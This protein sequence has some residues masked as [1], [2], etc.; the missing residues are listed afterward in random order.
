MK[1]YLLGAILAI[2]IA[3]PALSQTVAKKPSLMVVPSR[4]WCQ[5]NGFMQQYDNMGQTQ[6][7][8]DYQ[9]AFDNSKD[10]NLVVAKIGQL[11]AD[12]GF[13]LKLMSATLQSLQKEAA[14]DM[15]LTSK[16]TGAAVN[17]S[18]IDK[19]KKTAKADIWMEVYWSKTKV[20]FNT[21]VTF[22]LSGVDAYTD[23]QIANCQGT[24]QPSS[25]PEI[26]VLL[27]EAVIN[28]LNQF[29]EQLQVAF[30]DWFANG[31]I[32]KFRIKTWEDSEYDL[33]SEFDGEELG[34]I[35]EDWI[36]E[37]TVK[38]QFTTDDATENMMVFSNV[39]IPMISESGRALDARSWSRG[40]SKMLRDKYE[41]SSKVMT[42]GLGQAT[43]VI[44][45]K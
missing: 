38:G 9:A 40:L 12:R 36:A 27:A 26:D 34:V 8:P 19:L 20:G 18:P 23:L 2:I 7:V 42:Q 25:T 39:R 15:M 4:V 45:G 3:M 14:E 33:E 10:L 32:V 29:T 5:E 43:I 24:G 1:K 37:N 21:S 22:N 30:D 11:M 28:Y 44:G 13:P 16:E 31:R 41:I 6:L 35:I 17:E